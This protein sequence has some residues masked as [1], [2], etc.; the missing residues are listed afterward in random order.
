MEEL[1]FRPIVYVGTHAVAAPF[2]C[3]TG[4][5]LPP[6]GMDLDGQRLLGSQ[7]FEQE[8]QPSTEAV[9]A[10]DSQFPVRIGRDHSIK[11]QIPPCARE[12]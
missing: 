8:G 4:L 1:R 9:P 11:R 2:G 7:Y 6:V 10:R 3:E 12:P 5:S